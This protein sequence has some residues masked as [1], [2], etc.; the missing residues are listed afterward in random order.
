MMVAFYYARIQTLAPIDFLQIV[1]DD[2]QIIIHLTERD[3]QTER[4]TDRQGQRQ[5]KSEKN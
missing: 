3:K 1:P 4:Q 5:R 2:I